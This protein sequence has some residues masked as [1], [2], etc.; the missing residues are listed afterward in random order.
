MNDEG[1]EWRSL[2]NVMFEALGARGLCRDQVRSELHT[3]SYRSERAVNKRIFSI[4]VLSKEDTQR[5]FPFLVRPALPI[6]NFRQNEPLVFCHYPLEVVIF[7]S[8]RSLSSEVAASDFR[9]F[10]IQLPQVTKSKKDGE[11]RKTSTLKT[12]RAEEIKIIRRL[13]A[14]VINFT[15]NRDSMI[16]FH[17]TLN[18]LF[19]KELMQNEKVATIIFSSLRTVYTLGYTC[20]AFIIYL[21][22]LTYKSS[23][24]CITHNLFHFQLSTNCTL[25]FS[26]GFG[27]FWT[28]PDNFLYHLHMFYEIGQVTLNT[29][30]PCGVDSAF[31]LYIYQFSSIIHAM[32]FTLTNPLSTEKFS[33]LLKTCIVKHQKLLQCRNTLEHVYGSIIF[34]HMISN[35]MLLCGLIYDLTSTSVFNFD[36]ISASA[37]YAALKLVQ[38]FTYAWYGTFLTNAGDSFRKG[39]YFSKWPN[40]NLDYHVRTNVILIMMQKPMTLTAILSPV[41]VNMFTNVSI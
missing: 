14:C 23:Y 6:S 13:M 27:W 28:V 36:N 32:T 25:P 4:L 9:A 3:I 12:K 7:R 20:F 8:L 16:N 21:T 5:T 15:I 40:S 30:M 10:S 29:I 24:I 35:A 31:G 2:V 34:W 19:E 38:T 37:L 41:D 39:I 33:D 18:D 1:T 11:I 26:K 22:F 17:Q